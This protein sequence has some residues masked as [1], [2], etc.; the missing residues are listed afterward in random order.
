MKRKL[1]ILLLVAGGIALQFDAFGQQQVMFSQY[2][3]NAVAINPA[4]AGSADALSLSALA[5]YQWVGLDG[6]PNTQTF[7]AHTPI[8]RKNIA[9]GGL[10]MRD[11]I[12]VSTQNAGFG[13]FSYRVKFPSKGTLSMGLNFGFTNY[14][15]LNSQVNTGS[16]NDP[17]FVGDDLRG[18]SPNVGTGL[19]YYTDRVYFGA[20]APFLLNTYYGDSDNFNSVEQI[21]H[22]FL[23]AGYVL[24]VS[25][26]VK[27]KPNL[28][29]KM[30][31]GAPMQ[32]DLNAN[33]LFD[34]IIWAGVS[35]RS[36][37]SIDLLFSFQ[38]NPNLRFGYAYDIT[39][40]NLR[41]VSAGSHE[42]MLNYTLGLSKN[43]VV[44]PRY[45]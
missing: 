44:T 6:A 35:W 22:Y 38:I 1:S 18:F 34:E 27:F 15:A 45:F 13:Y 19:Y 21:R 7:S 2:M 26:L 17:S 41:N 16:G 31:D 28:L 30:V 43:K 39:T 11:E 24:D 32:F 14:K 3:F 8:R 29:V 10:F 25:P 36:F 20:S 5:R 23:M 42:V 4:Y 40:T 9:V 33:F 37:D 12:G